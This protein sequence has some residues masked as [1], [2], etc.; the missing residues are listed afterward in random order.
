MS[1]RL[2]RAPQ[3][4]RWLMP[5]H[6]GIA[7]TSQT[8][9]AGRVLLVEFEVPAPCLLDGLAYV[10]GTNSAGNVTGGVVGPVGRTSDSA[11]TAAVVAQSASTAQG[12]ANTLQVLTWTA[13]YAPAG[14]YYAALEGS[15]VTGTY[16]RLGNQLQAAGTGAQYDRA[17][18]YGA[19]TDPTPVVT[20]TGSALPG[21]RVR[22]A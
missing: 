11:A 2:T 3:Q 13:V 8:F 17:G 21:L 1:I 14:I 18:G 15:D 5:V 10:V 20:E 19:L 7:A 6:G 4:G 9:T 22:V 12:T 16:M